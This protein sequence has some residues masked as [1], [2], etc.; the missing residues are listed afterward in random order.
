MAK[1]PELITELYTGDGRRVTPEE[2]IA[3][4]GGVA[5]LEGM[6]RE[7]LKYAVGSRV[8]A[9]VSRCK[10]NPEL[11]AKIQARAAELDRLEA[12]AHG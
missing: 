10:K 11:W 3:A 2:V 8:Y 1:Q 4:G 12:E 5:V 7:A 9:Y 6:G